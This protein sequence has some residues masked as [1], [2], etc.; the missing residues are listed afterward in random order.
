[1]KF[2]EVEKEEIREKENEKKKNW[3]ETREMRKDKGKGEKEGE[4]GRIDRKNK[5][6][7][8]GKIVITFEWVMP[9]SISTIGLCLFS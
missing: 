7:Q 8:Q 9:N 1:M 5:E 3:R 6:I 2:L 4:E